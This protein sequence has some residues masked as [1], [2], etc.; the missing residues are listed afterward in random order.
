MSPVGVCFGSN[1]LRVRKVISLLNWNSGFSFKPP[2]ANSMVYP[3]IQVCEMPI[4]FIR[5]L[6]IKN[7]EFKVP[8]S[9]ANSNSD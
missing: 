2:A 1:K 5:C 7:L 9:P 4:S 8:E 3:G 6:D